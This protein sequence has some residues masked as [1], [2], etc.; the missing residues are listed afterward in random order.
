MIKKY[1]FKNS[2]TWTFNKEN[3]NLATESVRQYSIQYG[4]LG[5]KE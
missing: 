1:L 4:I 5:T 2:S 3:K